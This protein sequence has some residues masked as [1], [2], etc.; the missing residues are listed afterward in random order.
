MGHEECGFDV[1]AVGILA[2]SIEHLLVE[3]NVVVVDGIVEGDGDHLRDVFGGQVA[4]RGRAVL[5]AEAV[6]QHTHRWITWRRTIRIGFGVYSGSRQSRLI[7]RRAAKVAFALFHEFETRLTRRS[8]SLRL[9]RKKKAKPKKAGESH[10]K[11]SKRAR[12]KKKIRSRKHKNLRFRSKTLIIY[13]ST[14]AGVITK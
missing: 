13:G 10:T 5:R 9:C 4:G 6:G 14:P 8:S 11:R 2:L 12:S 1:A 3:L 7:S